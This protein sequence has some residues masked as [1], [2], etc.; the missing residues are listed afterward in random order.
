MV[1]Y[2]TYYSSNGLLGLYC[3]NEGRMTLEWMSVEMLPYLS[4][5]LPHF[6]GWQREP[7]IYYI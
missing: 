6:G 5:K 7:G 1:I 3:F 2:V 4:P